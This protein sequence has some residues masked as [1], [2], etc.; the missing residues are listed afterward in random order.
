MADFDLNIGPDLPPKTDYR[1]GCIGA[2]FIMRDV[3][4]AAYREA[5]FDVVA[6]ASR[7]PEHAR[8]A[9]QQNGIETVYD[10]WSELLDDERI[11]IVDIAFPPDQQLEIVREAVK[12][13]HVK[14]VLTQKPAAFTLRE[15]EEIVRAAA[16][17]NKRLAVNHNMRYDQSMRALKT[18]LARGELG[19]PV[20]AEIVMN[21]RP[22]WQEFIKPYGRIALL[23]MSIH[24]LDAFRF[25]FGDPA[26]VLC[27]VRRDP[28]LDFE[29]IDGMAF[30]VL[31]W[32][33]D[34][35][36]VGIDNC[37]TWADHRIEWRVEGTEGVAK[38][39]I[40]WPDYPEGSPSTIA[41]T[42]RTMD[43]RWESPRWEERWFPQA[44]KG[45]M[46]QL[47]RAIQDDAEPEISGT[48]TLGTMALCE[49]AYR[50]VTEG[51][52]ITVTEMLS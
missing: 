4:L 14:G 51:R 33:N 1:I 8:A 48:T 46:G 39:T 17:A 23:N 21:A 30:Y 32:D 11:E 31:E 26:R 22:H 3:H 20:V 2:G 52:A 45:T 24:H 40:G 29:H 47:M 25:L 12:R 41:W 36:A 16:A 50:S 13:P 5:G 37:F 38:G 7:T 19:Q 10:T 28:S 27:S 18:L 44:F 34:L 6:I 43:G 49:A 9:A 15:A 35:R 42:T